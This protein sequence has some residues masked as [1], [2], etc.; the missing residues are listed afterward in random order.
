MGKP[1]PQSAVPGDPGWDIA[2][3]RIARGLAPPLDACVQALTLRFQA[4]G[5]HCELQSAQT[6]RGL[7]MFLSVVGCRGL[8]FIVDLTLID[9]IAVGRGRGAALDVRLLDACGDT[10]AHCAAATDA[11]EPAWPTDADAVLATTDLARAANSVFVM[12]LGHFGLI[13]DTQ[14]AQ[15]HG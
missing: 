10:V 13:P 15:P 3:T 14:P 4:I 2:F 5:L 6:P 9:G 12:A 7:S 11:E 8:L 1:S